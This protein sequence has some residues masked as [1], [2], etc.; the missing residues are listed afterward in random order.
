[1]YS[2][3]HF[4]TPHQTFVLVI[5]LLLGVSFSLTSCGNTEQ[6]QQ[7][8]QAVASLEAKVKQQGWDMS[9]K[10]SEISSLKSKLS[11]AEN[12]ATRLRFDLQT[13]NNK[14]NSAR[15]GLPF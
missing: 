15:L 12:E 10:E 1:M 14:V 13:C 2:L 5:A 3:Q 11:Y 7:L 4:S 6:I 8:E 9:R